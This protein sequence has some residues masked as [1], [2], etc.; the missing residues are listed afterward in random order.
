MCWE[1]KEYFMDIL[2]HA[3]DWTQGYPDTTQS[4]TS[5]NVMTQKGMQT[6]YLKGTNTYHCL[7]SSNLTFL[8]ET[9]LICYLSQ[10]WKKTS[11]ISQWNISVG[12]LKVIK[13]RLPK[14]SFVVNQSR[15]LDYI[16]PRVLIT[17][18]RGLSLLLT[19]HVTLEQ[20]SRQT[21]KAYLW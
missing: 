8:L 6:L 21:E 7:P 16:S 4:G 18:L 2:L 10:K 1:A 3:D 12:E 19:Y 13:Q 17:G 11:V 5:D 9:I 14:L 15:G 20:E